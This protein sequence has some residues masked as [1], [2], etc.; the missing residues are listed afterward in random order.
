M[1]F[2]ESVARAVIDICRGLEDR[3]AVLFLGSGVNHGVFNDKGEPFPLGAG[4]SRM[5][6]TDLLAAPDF[7]TSLD[8]AADIA[9]EQVGDK[10]LN[11][12]I[13]EK[14]A[15]FKPSTVHLDIAQLPWDVIYTTNYDL[16][17]EQAFEFPD[18]EPA[19][20]LKPVV[21]SR[22]D[23]GH[24]TEHDII[25]YKLHGCMTQ[26]NSKEGRL[27]L[28]KDDFRFYEQYR[29][30][31]FSR[32]SRDLSERTF[33]FVGYAMQD[34]NLR[35]ILDDCKKELD[36]IG[37]PSGYC[38]RPGFNPVEETHFKSKYNIQLLRSDAAE[39]LNLLKEAWFAQSRKP[40]SFVE[41]H[42]LGPA[43]S[44]FEKIGESFYVLDPSRYVG[45][46]S[47]ERFFQGAEP[48]WADIRD[49]IPPKREHFY[50]ILDSLLAELT[51]ADSPASSYL[52]TGS[53][54]TGKTTLLH[55]LLWE[56]AT[57]SDVPVLC[58]IPGT[59]LDPKLLAVLSKER[60]PKRFVIGVRHAGECAADLGNFLAEVRRRKIPVTLLLEERGNQWRAA[61]NG[62]SGKLAS[63]EFLL[64]RLSESE[65]NEILDALSKHGQLGKLT[66]TPRDY[67]IA[68]FR[69]LAHRQ[70]LVA[71]RELT[72]ATTFDDIIRDEYSKIPSPTAKR[73]YE[74]V[75]AIGQLDLPLRY[76]VLQHILGIGWSD[77]GKE[78]FAPAEGILV[79]KE[80]SGMSRHNADMRIKV[81]HPTIGSV[82]FAM[83]AP[84]DHSKFEILTSI[85]ERLD[86][87]HS[88]DR[89]LLYGIVRGK[90]LI[91]TFASPEN[92]RAVYDRLAQI[93]PNDPFVLQHRSILE[94]DLDAP[95]QALKYAR[96][97]VKLRPN[98]LSLENT[99]G[100]ALEL[101]ARRTPLVERITRR[102][103]QT[104]AHKIFD[105]GIRREPHRAHNYIGKVLL[106]RQEMREA[107]NAAEKMIVQA[108]AV[109]FLEEAQEVT[110]DSTIISHYLGEEID[111]LGDTPSAI[112]TLKEA[113]KLD[114]AESR[115]RALLIKLLIK[116]N[117]LDEALELGFEGL[118][119]APTAWRIQ[120]LVARLAKAKKLPLATVEGHYQAA[121]R[122]NRGDVAIAVELGAYLFMQGETTKAGQVFERNREID[123]N[124]YERSRIRLYCE[125]EH[126]KR[127][128][129]SGKV[130][131]V[132]GYNG[133][134][135]TIPVNLEV[136]FWRD[137]S[138]LAD[139][140]PGDTVSFAIGFNSYGPIARSIQRERVKTQL[141][142]S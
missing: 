132:K 141:E 64:D 47:A 42:Q 71:L 98:N 102:A 73:A 74:Y 122:Q 80:F 85:L 57:G 83:V 119:L 113:L 22:Q 53:A 45:D 26:A 46:S 54:G 39:F 91:G 123:L 109:S 17:V 118:R 28:T 55:S 139:L 131:S 95:E 41:R 86:P 108:K 107:D 59:P 43:K 24:F 93:L 67:Q 19:G 133:M 32:L 10:V 21:S 114:P 110:E 130:S 65:M 94:R 78:V 44:T 125:D 33:V 51:E 134:L 121:I 49:E 138:L 96:A 70:L 62:I 84:D 104:E 66:D 40:V 15:R 76:S 18:M 111:S 79:S 115:L 68:H 77:L 60:A 29:K 13:F 2:D 90:E 50:T 72:L 1:E 27:I 9:R 12:Y 124:G 87:G 120:L 5:I 58:H 35:A 11:E 127:Q 3:T 101:A 99:L 142:R 36:V 8:E 89:R 97:A 38:V 63:A 103:L 106:A 126:G 82:I 56:I 136:F 75:S 30:R 116:E 14:F 61:T 117:N 135:L 20:R 34:P 105:E 23:V 16:L 128:R 140:K 31:L 137:N 100:F 92:R 112:N 129:F 88:E 69:D 37:L 52:I 4:L 25:Y 81:R 48:T 7:E 6:C